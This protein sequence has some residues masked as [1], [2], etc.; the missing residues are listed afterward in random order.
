MQVLLA[1]LVA[2]IFGLA[3]AQAPLYR[4]TMPDG[5]KIISE[6]PMPGAVKVEELKVSPGNYAPGS[7]APRAAPV[8]AKKSATPAAAKGGRAAQRAAAEEEL[9]TAQAGYD[10]ALANS[11]KGREETP[12]DR[13][14]TAKGGARFSDEYEK[15]Q[16]QLQAELAAAEA[17]L[18]A[19]R[20]QFN[21]LR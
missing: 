5:K 8:D 10:A 16:A 4:S 19:A 3:I 2:A 9:R 20:K 15:R 6:R 1:A 21:D 12:G 17:R 13:Q 7:P 18:Q 14:G 11:A